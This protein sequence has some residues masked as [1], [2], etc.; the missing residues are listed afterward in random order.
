MCPRDGVEGAAF[1]E[2]P[3]RISFLGS[4]SISFQLSF[5][6]LLRGG[7]E[8]LHSAERNGIL[9]DPLN[10]TLKSMLSLRLILILHSDRNSGLQVM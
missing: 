8:I 9:E 7:Q 1:N 6:L 2:L 4:F 5:H 10:V 3:A